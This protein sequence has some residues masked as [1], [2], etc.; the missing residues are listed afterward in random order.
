MF[1]SRKKLEPPEIASA[2]GIFVWD[3]DAVWICDDYAWHD[4]FIY[5]RYWGRR[6][7]VADLPRFAEILRELDRFIELALS[8]EQ[9]EIAR[10]EHS[11]QEITLEGIDIDPS[12]ASI[13]F[14][15]HFSFERWPDGN[16]GVHF[17][18]DEVVSSCV[19]D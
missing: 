12:N 7:D 6:F 1:W 13:D 15:L 19:D 14:E 17:R 18:G 9:A 8:H 16:L 10:Q 2:N 3:G 11:P 4:D 5:L